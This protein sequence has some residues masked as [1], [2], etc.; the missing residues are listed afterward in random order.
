VTPRHPDTDRPLR[1]GP[2]THVY[3]D[4]GFVTEWTVV[5]LTD[6]DGVDHLFHVPSIILDMERQLV[7]ADFYAG[8]R[9]PAEPEAPDLCDGCGA[10]RL[11]MRHYIGCPM[12]ATH[13]W[14]PV[15]DAT[16]PP[17][18]DDGT[19][20]ALV[21]ALKYAIQDFETGSPESGLR[22]VRIA[23]RLATPPTDD[24]PDQEAS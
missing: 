4:A 16:P 21:R 7:A 18:L 24:T 23:L 2:N 10:S 9:L 14:D 8:V 1:D 5:P 3:R 17:A 12:V 22:E 6:P 11:S 19:L 13:R 15:L 20:N